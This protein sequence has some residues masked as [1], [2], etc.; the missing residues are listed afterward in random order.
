MWTSRGV[1]AECLLGGWRCELPAT[2][3]QARCERAKAKTSAA[4]AAAGVLASRGAAA[5]RANARAQRADTLTGRPAPLRRHGHSP[6]GM[7]TRPPHG[8]R[9]LRRARG[10]SRARPADTGRA[11][12]TQPTRRNDAVQAKRHSART[13]QR[14]EWGACDGSQLIAHR[15]IA[16]PRRQPPTPAT[17]SEVCPTRVRL[18]A[19]RC[20]R[21]SVSGLTA[22]RCR[23]ALVW[24]GQ[25]PAVRASRVTWVELGRLDTGAQNSTSALAYTLAGRSLSRWR[26]LPAAADCPLSLAL[27][28]RRLAHQLLLPR[29]PPAIAPT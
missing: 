1:R 3:S 28:Y 24:S 26:T 4:A 23:P 17:H 11:G 21:P 20:L 18:S 7:A 16:R 29:R 19:S 12:R 15:S 14:D 22:A 2:R 10:L 5:R 8:V 9:M 27:W 13:D 6:H 25:W